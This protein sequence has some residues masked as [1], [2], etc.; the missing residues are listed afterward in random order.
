MH[1]PHVN[2]TI[3][4]GMQAWHSSQRYTSS[5]VSLGRTHVL[6]SWLLR[7]ASDIAI[8]W[9]APVDYIRD[10]VVPS[11][12]VGAE[13][14]GRPAPPVIAETAC[15]LCE[16]PAEVLETVRREMGFYLAMPAYRA[17][18]DRAGLGPVDEKLAD[19]W[20]AEL[21]DAVIPW[22]TP[23]RIGQGV[24]AYFAAGADEVALSPVGVGSDPSGSYEK[25][26]EVLGE[27]A[28]SG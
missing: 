10:T 4:V 3:P 12:R 17:L 25:T 20:T 21:I 23:D 7:C 11:V 24:E 13:R 26:L 15:L 16:D 5:S 9:L 14:A 22:G 27:I 18:F 6:F 1:R 2:L 28:R 19:G 8:P